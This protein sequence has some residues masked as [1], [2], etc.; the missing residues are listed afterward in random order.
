[1]TLD[2]YLV[3]K[4]SETR[5]IIIR[6]AQVYWAKRL[7]WGSLMPTQGSLVG[8]GTAAIWGGGIVNRI[9]G[10]IKVVLCRMLG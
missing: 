2:Q 9:A 3:T 7:A 5:T 6:I 1:M 10:E 8:L 4:L